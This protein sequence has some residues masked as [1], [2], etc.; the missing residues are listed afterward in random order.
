MNIILILLPPEILKKNRDVKT[1][2]YLDGRGKGT[3]NQ[4]KV[5]VSK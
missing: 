2:G 1:D 4:K 3:G 5:Q